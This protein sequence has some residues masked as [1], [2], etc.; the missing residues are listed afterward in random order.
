VIRQSGVYHRFNTATLQN[1]FVLFNPNPNTVADQ[2]IQSL[3]LD[4]YQE[5]SKKGPLWLHDVFLSTHLPAWRRYIASL[6][7]ELLPIVSFENPRQD[8]LALA[9]IR[10]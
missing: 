3:L 8:E 2:K 10:I 1:L 9:C 4:H 5:A 6:E 7:R